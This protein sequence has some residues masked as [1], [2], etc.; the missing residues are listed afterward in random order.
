MGYLK[1][2][3]TIDGPSCRYEVRAMLGAGIHGRKFQA[4]RVTN[5]SPVAQGATAGS[6]AVV[7]IE[8]VAPGLRANWDA[9]ELIVRESCF[10][11]RLR[12]EDLVPPPELFAW[13]GT[14]LT[15]VERL[16]L[17]SVQPDEKAELN[18][19]PSLMIVRQPS[20]AETL[21]GAIALGKRFTPGEIEAIYRS[22]LRALEYLHSLCPGV[23]HNNI[24]A[25]SIVLEPHG[26]QMQGLSLMPV[27]VGSANV[28]LR[29][30]AETIL[31][32]ATHARPG[33]RDWAGE[34]TVTNLPPRLREVLAEA[35]QG[36]GGRRRGSAVQTLASLDASRPGTLGRLWERR[37]SN[38]VA[39]VGVALLAATASAFHVS[40]QRT[41]PS[42]SPRASNASSQPVGYPS[43]GPDHD[44]DRDSDP[45]YR[46]WSGI[47]CTS[48]DYPPLRWTGR[49]VDGGKQMLTD[50]SVC[51]LEIAPT[52][53][54][55]PTACQLTLRCE[56]IRG[57]LASGWKGECA[58]RESAVPGGSRYDV[59]M[60][61]ELHE[62]NERERAT[63]NSFA[64]DTSKARLRLTAWSPS[65]G[66]D[67]ATVALD[68][69]APHEARETGAIAESRRQVGRATEASGRAAA[70]AGS[71]CWM[72]V[73]PRHVAGGNCQVRA[74]CGGRVLYDDT[75]VCGHTSEAP[76]AGSFTILS[77]EK[78]SVFDGTPMFDL[79][80][81]EETKVV[82]ISDHG[83]DG[84]FSVRIS[85]AAATP[86]H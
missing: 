81:D 22:G 23:F 74:G 46:D 31:F 21:G 12:H 60:G 50:G 36:R 16:L 52:D 68:A 27:G 48:G 18:A 62:L 10:L 64:L 47:G 51:A 38:R 15:V 55:R 32:A 57:F 8:E 26:A 39:A 2:G 44:G 49:V 29:Q 9:F 43:P 33:S 24:H 11:A 84:S 73:E 30:L 61:T 19:I 65:G 86:P 40:E 66:Y 13:D 82:T 34:R 4:M 58:V 71:A 63:L 14:N 28:D 59:R 42:A 75:R 37:P 35:I 79:G 17:S 78:I 54:D 67:E 53:R 1:T 80:G 76:W 20:T 45:C 5:G 7:E 41:P 3:V 56:G 6:S 83:L 25:D 85:L 77:D 69:P 70:L 72:S